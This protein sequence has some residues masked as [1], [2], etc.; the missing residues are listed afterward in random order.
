MDSGVPVENGRLKPI[1]LTVTCFKCDF[2]T[3]GIGG[4]SCEKQEDLWTK[5]TE[6][7]TKFLEPGRVD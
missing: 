4:L 6:E 1:V 7:D 5:H 2:L 3:A